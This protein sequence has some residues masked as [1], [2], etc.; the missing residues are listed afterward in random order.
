[1]KT[2][3]T[4]SIAGL[5]AA[6]LSAIAV[7]ASTESEQSTNKVSWTGV[8][9]CEKYS[10]TNEHGCDLEFEN[11]DTSKT[12]SVVESPDLLKRHCANDRDLKVKVD[13]E[14]TPKFL[15]WGGNLKI[16]SFEVI[17]ELS[18]MPETAKLSARPRTIREGGK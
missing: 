3:K 1:M 14:L 12:I 9:R 6:G 7:M 17:E 8:V 5:I 11:G 4:M 10:H 15:F 18:P 16:S 2:L 13:G